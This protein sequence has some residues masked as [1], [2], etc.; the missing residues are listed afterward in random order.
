MLSE[1][2]FLLVGIFGTLAVVYGRKAVQAYQSY[3][4]RAEY[5][6]WSQ[7]GNGRPPRW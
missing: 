1:V 5:R 6:N 4:Q 3:Q 7:E 2:C